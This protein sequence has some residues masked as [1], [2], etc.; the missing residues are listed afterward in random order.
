MNSVLKFRKVLANALYQI[1]I[2]L[3]N[4]KKKKRPKPEILEYNMRI[5]YTF[6]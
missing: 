4:L 5:L 1:T 3:F 2:F 6:Y